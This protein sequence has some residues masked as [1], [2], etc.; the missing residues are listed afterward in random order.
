MRRNLL[1]VLAFALVLVFAAGLVPVALADQDVRIRDTA[2]SESLGLRAAMTGAVSD[3]AA[4]GVTGPDGALTVSEVIAGEKNI[5]TIVTEEPIDLKG[6]YTL[7]YG[8]ESME[9]RMP[10]WYSTADFE[11]RYTYEGDDLGAVWTKEQTVFRVWAP[12]AESVSVCP[13][14]CFMVL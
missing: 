7:T 9:I 6:A 4:F 8:G 14:P 2:Y 3:T 13:L 1:R 11:D 10:I 12:T 5:Y